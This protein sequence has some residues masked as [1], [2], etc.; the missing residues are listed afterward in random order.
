MKNTLSNYENIQ[1]LKKAILLFGFLLLTTFAKSQ[2]SQEVIREFQNYINQDWAVAKN[3]LIILKTD[4]NI[5]E[6]LDRTL[7]KIAIKGIDG[8]V[9]EIA[10]ILYEKKQIKYLSHEFRKNMEI[11][12]KNLLHVIKAK[13]YPNI[14]LQLPDLGLY[15]YNFINEAQPMDCETAKTGTII[16]IN[17]S[18]NPYDVYIDNIL[19]GRIQGKSR[20]E[21]ILLKEA[22]NRILYAKQ[23][24]GYLLS[25]TERTNYINIISCSD[26]SWQFP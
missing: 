11:R 1:P 21:K 17:N 26:N 12:I 6:M 9:D 2:T 18:S 14:L 20:T 25:P 8:G 22:D 13:D 4:P 3:G 5:I 16:L 23:V 15:I 19:L 24:S 10:N 7:Q